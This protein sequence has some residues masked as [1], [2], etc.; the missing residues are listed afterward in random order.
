MH[1]IEKTKKNL[2]ICPVHNEQDTI[3]TFY[4]N[5]RKHYL[6]DVVFIDDGSMDRSRAFLFEI[7]GPETFL[8]RHPERLG[9]GA[10]LLSGFKFSMERDYQ[11][12]I[13]LDVDLQHNP[14]EIPIFLDELD[15][16]SVV[17]GSRY[18]YPSEHLNVP[19][20]RL[21]INR[22][23]SGLIKRLYAIHFTDPFCGYRGYRVGALKKMALTQGSYGLGLEIILEII[24]T[25]TPFKEIP[26]K[27]IYNNHLRKFLDGLDDP[28]ARLLY[29]LEVLS[30]KR[31]FLPRQENHIRHHHAIH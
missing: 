12:I 31:A 23:I 19:W 2:V 29:Y 30:A 8:I 13:T 9:Y 15:Q 3:A 7:T 28:R 17:L 11:K 6:Q 27:V 16:E 5:L 10:A 22:Y 1:Q 18:L 24:R 21:A 14:G 26:I 4:H 20:A 25:G